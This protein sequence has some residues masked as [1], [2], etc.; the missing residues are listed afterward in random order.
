[1]TCMD[2]KEK[3][4]LSPEQAQAILDLKLQ[5]TNLEQD[6]IFDDYKKEIEAI[7]NF[8]KILTNS[9]ELHKVMKNEL[10]EIKNEYGEPRRSIVSSD[11]G[12]LKKKI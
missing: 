3:Y 6:K 11:E 5:L 7:R 1:M 8:I 10:E 9:D 4:K 12:E 2:L